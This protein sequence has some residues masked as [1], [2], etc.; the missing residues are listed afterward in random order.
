MHVN[1]GF[2]KPYDTQKNMACHDKYWCHKSKM[3]KNLWCDKKSWISMKIYNTLLPNDM[4]YHYHMK[5]QV[6]INCKG[7]QYSQL[8][9]KWN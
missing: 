3:H 6:F 5:D 8:A 4:P 2:Q 9:N 7:Q 1:L